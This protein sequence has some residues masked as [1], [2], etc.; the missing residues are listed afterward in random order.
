M[1]IPRD[2]EVHAFKVQGP[3]RSISMND[4]KRPRHSSSATDPED[5]SPHALAPLTLVF[6]L[7]K[8]PYPCPMPNPKLLKRSS[9]LVV[10]PGLPI[11]SAA[12]SP[13]PCQPQGINVD[14]TDTQQRTQV[15]QL[16]KLPSPAPS[17]HPM[18]QAK[19]QGLLLD[20]HQTRVA[21]ARVN[22]NITI[23]PT[24]HSVSQPVIPSYGTLGTVKWKP[25][26]RVQRAA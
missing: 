24:A 10:F 23:K 20:A 2:T 14:E 4:L 22:H 12:K 3:M 5:T 8:F 6:F 7:L 9:H 19:V 21:G 26:S 11:G 1:R 17:T 13:I 16:S 25:S 18:S 15:I